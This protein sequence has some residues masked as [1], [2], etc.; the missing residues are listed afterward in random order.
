MVQVKV[1]CLQIL[2]KIVYTPT[3]GIIF[4]RGKIGSLLEVGTGFHPDLTGR[5]KMFILMGLF[6]V[7]LKRMLTLNL[8][9]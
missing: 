8:I 2:S 1:H 7:C 3:N 5:E 6:L 4:T 9:A